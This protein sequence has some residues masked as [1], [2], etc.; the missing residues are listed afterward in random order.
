MPVQQNTMAKA[1]LLEG[2]HAIEH[3]RWYGR[4]ACQAWQNTDTVRLIDP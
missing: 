1:M 2:V 4:E 3:T